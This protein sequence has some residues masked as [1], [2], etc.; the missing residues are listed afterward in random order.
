MNKKGMYLKLVVAFAVLIVLGFLAMTLVGSR[1]VQENFKSC[2]YKNVHPDVIAKDYIADAE[3]KME[4]S[5]LGP[6]FSS[7][8]I[9]DSLNKSGAIFVEKKFEEV[10]SYTANILSQGKVCAW[11][12]GRMEFGPRALG[13]RSILADP[14]SSKTQKELNMK[15][16]YRESF[17]PFA[18]AIIEEDLNQWFDL[19]N[20]SLDNFLSL[21]IDESYYKKDT[22]ARLIL[23][24]FIELFLL[25]KIAYIYNDYSRY[26]LKKINNTK[27]Y[28]LDEGSLFLEIKSKL[29][30]G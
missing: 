13:N 30:N 12:Q 6:Q 22:S 5:Y 8:E 7:I 1:K 14:R 29:L 27:K 9:K 17:R 4:G 3:D 18:P 25:K 26:F 19:K 15:V 24:D 20:I 21:L 23:F 28:N 16:K 2:P 10:L 11:F